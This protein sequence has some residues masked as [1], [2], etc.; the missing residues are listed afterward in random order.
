MQYLKQGSQSYNVELDF[1]YS[2]CLIVHD[3]KPAPEANVFSYVHVMLLM[4]LIVKKK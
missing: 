2:A 1:V 4:K 3:S